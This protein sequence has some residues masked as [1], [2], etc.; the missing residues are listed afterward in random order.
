M[1]RVAITAL[2]CTVLLLAGCGSSADDPADAP[3]AEVTHRSEPEPTTAPEL[4]P[5][6][7]ADTSE[8]TVQQWASRVAEGA[9]GVRESYTEWETTN[10]CLPGDEDFICTANM[11]T[12]SYSASTLATLLE[13]GTNVG[14][15]GYIGD[16]PAEV[17]NL[18]EETK[19]AATQ[20]S[21]TAKTA[22]DACMNGTDECMGTSMAMS[23]SYG[24]LMNQLNAWQPYGVGR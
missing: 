8:A 21:E 2:A 20:A 15:P 9:G 7:T 10:G 12:M 19:A 13:A 4:A 3:V 6:P 5:T 14:A 17:A 18:V 11:L 24:L 23:V 1:R 16:P 22:W